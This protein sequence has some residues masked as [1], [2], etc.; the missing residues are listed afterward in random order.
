M[1]DSSK[2]R[3]VIPESYRNQYV[4]GRTLSPLLEITVSDYLEK[5]ATPQQ[6]EMGADLADWV[7]EERRNDRASMK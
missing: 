2:L 7:M 5:N 1:A 3:K 4:S 6:R